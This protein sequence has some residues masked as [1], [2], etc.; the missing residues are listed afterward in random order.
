MTDL[1]SPSPYA[2]LDA[3]TP[4]ER[5]A[6]IGR[7]QHQRREEW[8]DDA[9]RARNYQARIA[10]LEIALREIEWSNN[11]EWQSLRA[12]TALRVPPAA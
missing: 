11:S 8:C 4:A 10:E 5:Q 2:Y 1:L 6:E 7:R 3:L 9:R 12:R